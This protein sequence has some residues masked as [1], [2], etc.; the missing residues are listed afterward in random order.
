MTNKSEQFMA[1]HINLD[2]YKHNGFLI[3]PNFMDDTVC[4]QLIQRSTQLIHDYWMEDCKTIFSAKN[5]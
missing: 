5:Q 1:T 3:I 2:E 4:D